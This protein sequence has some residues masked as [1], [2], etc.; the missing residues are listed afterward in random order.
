MQLCFHA[1]VLWHLQRAWN[2]HTAARFARNLQVE[3]SVAVLRAIVQEQLHLS[4]LPR[5]ELQQDLPQDYEVEGGKRLVL[6]LEGE[7]AVVERLR[8]YVVQGNLLDVVEVGFRDGIDL[9]GRAR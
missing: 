3:G 5:K 4:E 7:A 6:F 1:F 2:L 8:A 9:E